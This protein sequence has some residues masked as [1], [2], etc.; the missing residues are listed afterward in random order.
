[1]IFLFCFCFYADTN[2]RKNDDI[3]A[4]FHSTT[5]YIAKHEDQTGSSYH[6]YTLINDY[7]YN[8]D[9]DWLEEF[10]KIKFYIN[11]LHKELFYKEE[12]LLT[13]NTKSSLEYEIICEIVNYFL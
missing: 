2:D 12:D 1:M 5:D 13:L 8:F 7:F 3:L 6:I 4:R 11:I 10:K 9:S